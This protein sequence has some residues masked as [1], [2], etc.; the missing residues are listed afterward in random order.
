MT[1]KKNRMAAV[2]KVAKIRE[3]K[4]TATHAA[5]LREIEAARQRFIEAQHR[6]TPDPHRGSVDELRR[7]R[8][9]TAA[10]A[11]TALLEQAHLTDQIERAVQERNEMLAAMRYRRT[12]ERIDE[13]HKLAWAAL[14]TQAAER[15]MD[16]IAVAGWQRR[17]R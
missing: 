4:T 7:R 8:E 14:A 15:A 5:R 13:K 6:A 2:L 10:S 1:K 9:M 16:D 12:V 11:R 3:D 17:N